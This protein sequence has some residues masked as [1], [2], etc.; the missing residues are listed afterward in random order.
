MKSKDKIVKS[1]IELM[2]TH[3]FEEIT[4]KDIIRTG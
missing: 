4:V 1:L 3:E 2:E